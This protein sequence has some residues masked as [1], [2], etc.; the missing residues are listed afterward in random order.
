MY[1]QFEPQKR[2]TYN[3]NTHRLLTIPLLAGIAIIARQFSDNGYVGIKLSSLLRYNNKTKQ[4][5]K[6]KPEHT[7]PH[8]QLQIQ[9]Q[10]ISVI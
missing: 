1:W 10:F 3:K 5:K 7:W 4:K 8:V 9:S 2:G 6:P